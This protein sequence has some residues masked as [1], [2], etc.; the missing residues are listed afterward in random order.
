MPKGINELIMARSC[1]FACTCFIFESN[2]RI[3]TKFGIGLHNKLSDQFNF[4]SC[5]SN[6]T[7]TLHYCEIEFCR[8][9]QKLFTVQ[10]ISMLL[11]T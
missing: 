8:V 7:T 5:R 11:K 3:S 1:P 6:I 10:N 2:E 9:S 4:S